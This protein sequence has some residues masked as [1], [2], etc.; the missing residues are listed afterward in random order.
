MVTESANDR[1]QDGP[2][3]NY[4]SHMVNGDAGIELFCSPLVSNTLCFCIEHAKITNS[5]IC[6]EVFSLIYAYRVK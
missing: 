5:Y 6:G 1:L 3:P 4:N 2:E